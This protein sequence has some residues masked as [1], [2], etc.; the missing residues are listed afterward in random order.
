MK[1]EPWEV[2]RRILE[3][4]Q[5][6]GIGTDVLLPQD[7]GQAGKAQVQYLTRQLSGSVVRSSPETGSKELRASP[8]AS[9]V[10]AG[11]VSILRADWNRV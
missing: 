1:G 11:N 5:M 9:Q 10:A 2:E 8:F 3:T 6:D 4:A 7:P